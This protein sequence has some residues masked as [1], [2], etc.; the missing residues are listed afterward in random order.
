MIAPSPIQLYQGPYQG[1]DAWW[2]KRDPLTLVLLPQIG[3]RIVGMG[4]RHHNLAFTLPALQGR[5][6]SITETRDVRAYKRSLGFIYWGGDKT[7]LAPQGRWSDQLPFLDLD[8]GVY[9]WQVEQAAP[10]EVVVRMTSPICRET[11][12]QITRTV[13]ISAHQ[14]GWWVT[15]SLKNCSDQT[16]EWALWDVSMVYRPGQVYLPKRMDSSHPHGVKTFPEEGE[17]VTARGSVVTELGGLAVINCSEPRKFKFGV[18]AEPGWAL[19][20]FDAGEVGLIGH[21]KQFQGL[22]PGGYYA[23]GCTAEVYNSHEYP[24]LEL[25][26]HSPVVQLKPKARFVVQE[27]ANLF[28]VQGWPER[29]S[30]VHYA[31]E[32]ALTE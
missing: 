9:G 7:W 17:S 27:R 10:T 3:G 32:Q 19:G 31:I 28:P 21:F 25:E 30:D 11:G 4:W 26:L 20:I 13:A 16:A 6:L 23:H 15:H 18:D 8:S 29:E 2:I 14:P 5:L 12:M 24:Y 1:W 22:T